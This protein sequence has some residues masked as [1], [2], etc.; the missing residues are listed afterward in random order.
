MRDMAVPRVRE[1]AVPRVR[2]V[3]MSLQQVKIRLYIH[4]IG[5]NMSIS[6]GQKWTQSWSRQTTP[7]RSRRLK[8]IRIDEENSGNEHFIQGPHCEGNTKVTP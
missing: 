5:C 3:A 2:E 1:V 4:V 7:D 6:E 8:S